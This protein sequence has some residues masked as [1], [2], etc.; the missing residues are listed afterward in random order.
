MSR[1]F[2]ISPGADRDIDQQLDHFAQVNV[3][4]ALSFLDATQR[5]FADIAKM[6][7]IGSPVRFHHPRL[8]GLRRWPVKGFESYLIFYCYS[9]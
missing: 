8:T 6:P 4:V 3:D 5:T 7:G 9:D 2:Y 1:I